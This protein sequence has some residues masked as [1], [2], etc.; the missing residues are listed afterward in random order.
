MLQ[1]KLR[2]ASSFSGVLLRPFACIRPIQT[3]AADLLAHREMIGYCNFSNITFRR[4]TSPKTIKSPTTT[5]LPH[6]SE[7][8]RDELTYPPDALP[9]GRNVDTPVGYRRN[10]WI[11]ANPETILMDL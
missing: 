4:K 2:Y 5:L 6:L 11:I 3:L 7:R 10:L 8:E 1:R 9:G